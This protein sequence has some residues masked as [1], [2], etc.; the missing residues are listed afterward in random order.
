[1]TRKNNPA[2]LSQNLRPGDKLSE[3]PDLGSRIF[4]HNTFRLK[5]AGCKFR[6][7]VLRSKGRQKQALFRFL[8]RR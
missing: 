5:S 8:D 3:D 7:Q 1:M 4:Y 2:Y 6:P